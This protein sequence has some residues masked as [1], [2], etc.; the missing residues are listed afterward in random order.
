MKKRS[1]TMKELGATGSEVGKYRTS[2]QK[3]AAEK[4]RKAFTEE[5]PHPAF[6]A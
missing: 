2:N 3:E 6:E 4:R 1:Q 5:R